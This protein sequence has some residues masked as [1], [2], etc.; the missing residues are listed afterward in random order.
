M[1]SARYRHLWPV[2]QVNFN[3]TSLAGEGQ[4]TVFWLL[5]WA[6][7]VASQGAHSLAR[8][9]TRSLARWSQASPGTECREEEGGAAISSS[10]SSRRTMRGVLP[11]SPSHPPQLG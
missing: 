10:C 4:K 7:E 8:S 9:L 5:S 6:D 11:S 1:G 3:G 2:P